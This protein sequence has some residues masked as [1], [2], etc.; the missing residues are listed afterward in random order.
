MAKISTKNDKQDILALSLNK[1]YSIFSNA[2]H[3][4]N[5]HNI[6]DSNKSIEELLEQSGRLQLNT[7]QSFIKNLFNPMSEH[8]SLILIHGTGTGKTITSLS[9][10]VEYQKQY[11]EFI[12]VN[13][14]STYGDIR[15]IN[16][17]GYTKDIFKN[18]L[19]SHSEFG[20]VSDEEMR[21]LRSLRSMS[22]RSTTVIERLNS[23]TNKLHRRIGDRSM[24]GIFKF[25]G[26]RQLFIRVVN[27]MELANMIKESKKSADISK[28]DVATIRS[29]IRSGKVSI[30]RPFIETFRNSLTICDEMHNLY[31]QNDV[32]AYG[33]TIEIITDYFKEP[34]MY[35]PSW[36]INDQ[37]CIR[38]LYLSATPLSSS[39]FEIVPMINL[40]NNKS[41]RV[42]CSDLFD[43]DKMI[44][45]KGFNIISDKIS[46]HISYI[47]DD[48]PIQYPSSSFSGTFING[49][50]YLKFVRCPMSEVHTFTYTN[51]IRDNGNTI[52]ED[53]DDS[54]ISKMSNTLKDFVFETKLPNSKDKSTIYDLHYRYPSVIENIKKGNSIYTIN[55]DGILSSDTFQLQYLERYSTKYYNIMKTILDLKDPSHGKIFVYHPSVHST[56]TNLLTSIFKA[57][58]LIENNETPSSNSICMNCSLLMRDHKSKEGSCVF[59]PVRFTVVTGYISKTMVA[60]KLEQYNSESNID[61]SNIKILLGSRAMRESHTLKACRHLMVAHEPSSISELIQIIGRGVRKNSH[62]LAKPQD[63]NIVIYIFVHSLNMKYQKLKGRALSTSVEEQSYLE[64]M[65]LYQQILK[66]EELMFDKSLDYLI[67]FRFK[68]REVP[69]LI[70]DSFPLDYQLQEEYKTLKTY[71]VSKVGNIKSNSLYFNQDISICSYIIKRIM[72]EFQP[73]VIK[74]ELIK[75]IRDPPFSIDMDPSLI[76]D[77]T[78][79]YTLN[80]LVYGETPV[81]QINKTINH[82]TTIDS[83]IESSKIIIDQFGI[84]RCIRCKWLRDDITQKPFP[85]RNSKN[86]LLYLDAFD[87]SYTDMHKIV[88]ESDPPDYKYAVDM[89]A[90]SEQWY[91][92]VHIDEIVKELDG[93]FSKEQSIRGDIIKQLNQFTLDTHFKLVEYLIIAI[94]NKLFH[95]IPTD[96]SPDLIIQLMEMYQ[97]YHVIITIG[98]IAQSIVHSL[99]KQY[100]TQTGVS[101]QDAMRSTNKVSRISYKSIPIGHYVKFAARLVSNNSLIP[102]VTRSKD[103]PLPIYVWNEYSTITNSVKWSHPLK[104]YG[105]EERT[106]DVSYVFKIKD[107][108]SQTS[109]G[110][111]PMFMPHD[112]LFEIIKR[113]KINLTEGKSKIK[114]SVLVSVIK[115]FMLK[116]EVKYRQSNSANKIYYYSYERR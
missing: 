63:R 113:L 33:L 75:L 97:D 116:T 89:E 112:E 57:N 64:K 23:L 78:I 99:Y 74:S 72:L 13:K 100:L 8:D 32:N 42:T 4:T 94:I 47:M 83:L 81:L 104:I 48:N 34:K 49:I 27:Q 24:H 22:E 54:A 93:D 71:P 19:I 76:S 102:I 88:T 35:N 61:G 62:A 103:K 43:D 9:V 69:K 56:G 79:E 85:S 39:P 18:E 110:I 66:I 21:E 101:W 7:Y 96:V 50:P 84:K 5:N 36:S 91:E 29:W 37:H 3:V 67:N 58:G 65:R 95:N 30:N 28:L 20:F 16:V 46:G 98:D 87:F 45:P 105:Y 70:G 82:Y 108:A 31:Y 60:N 73:V 111:N 26:Y 59:T 25:Y 77:E 17:I 55:N 92:L 12:S 44:T 90:L 40:L 1:E 106:N 86:I 10:A 68:T 53:T 109:I 2:H 114:K 107:L 41:N 14:A 11:R 80:E 38:Y 6:T 51:H 115:D 52:V 15:S